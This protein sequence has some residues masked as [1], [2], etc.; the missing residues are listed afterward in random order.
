MSKKEF[1]C[2]DAMRMYVNENRTCVEIAEACGISEK[3]VRL[4]KAEG[5]WDLQRENNARSRR[6][7]H[8]EL[9]E[10]GR[11]VMDSIRKDMVAGK[12]V[13][14]ARFN[15]VCRICPQLLNVKEYEDLVRKS[16]VNAA[17][18]TREEI[19]S[20]ADK[21]IRGEDDEQK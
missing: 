1:K 2:A 6:L 4:W 11:A 10:F 18:V 17:P 16:G 15:T 20:L 7:F 12:P 9:Y 3:T 21:R 13:S 8:E 19:I 14:D 5:Q